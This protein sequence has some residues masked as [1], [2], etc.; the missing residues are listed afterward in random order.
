M[1]KTILITGATDGIG[2][3]TAQMLVEQ[4]HHVIV[5]GR[6][7]AKIDAVVAQLREI[8][9]GQVASVVADLSN[10]ADIA[11]M[12]AAVA[13]KVER[14]DV[15]INN[16][17][18]FT[19]GAPITADNLDVRFAVNTI[20]PY[21]LTKA[22]L[23]LLDANSRVVN[24]SS[25]AQAPVD[26]HALVNPVRLGDNA[27]YAQSKL[28]LTMWTKQWGEQ[29]KGQGPMLVAINPKSFLGSKMVK[30]AY[31]I[32]GNDLRLGADILVRAAL[33]DEFAD[34]H[35]RYFDND[36]ERFANP[37]PQAMSSANNQALIDTIEQ[38]LAQHSS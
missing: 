36:A 25:A 31:G 18:V 32:A 1:S 37:H 14:L 11:P 34:A 33:A 19:S 38:W 29:L 24:L 23:P 6:N 2:L 10:I 20:A 12:A 35:G 7:P 26:L 8:G 30:D 21:A 16:A 28:A 27:A 15:L 9:S 5:H 22:L 13:S 4:G 3:V 17:G